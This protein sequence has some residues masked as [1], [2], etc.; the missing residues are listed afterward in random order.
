MILQENLTLA[1]G[2]AIPKLG[3]GT[4]LIQND[5]AA[6]AVRD[7]VEVGYRHI[8]SAEAYE[9]EKGVGEGVRTCG[10]KRE[11]IFVTTKLA[12]R[13]KD[14][15][16][17]VRAIRQSVADLDIGYID[18]ML[19]HAPKPWGD[20]SGN[21]YS[22]GNRAVWKALEEAADAGFIRS[23]GVSNF[24]EEDI[25]NILSSCKTKPTVNQI[26]TFI[27]RTQTDLI[28]YSEQVGMVV[29]AYSPLGH[30]AVFQRTDLPTLAEKYG[31][32]VPQL[33][34]RYTLQLGTVSL[35]KTTSPARMKEN[36]AVDFVI[37]D[38]DMS[39]LRQIVL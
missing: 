21:R 13:I 31:V 35:P 12:A 7:A 20:K 25:D 32:T 30:G 24:L 19:V 23:I 27:G 33:C 39:L 15:H 38:E 37:S 28:R 18:L 4:W 11:E 10:L 3:L 16:E 2:F 29:E 17:A 6:K 36:A 14:Y 5:I 22:E 8:D 1:N 9:N 34:I 26:S